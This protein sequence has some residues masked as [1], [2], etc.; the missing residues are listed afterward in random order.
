M[1]RWELVRA[2]ELSLF[3]TLE[4]ESDF[5]SMLTVESESET[6]MSL[7]AGR[8]STFTSESAHFHFDVDL[9]WLGEEVLVDL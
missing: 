4:S 6:I 8:K 9:S 5:F 7:V 2:T 3:W 1:T